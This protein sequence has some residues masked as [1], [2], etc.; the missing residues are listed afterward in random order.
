MTG[1]FEHFDAPPGGSYRLVLAYADAS[2][3][4]SPP[5]DFD[6]GRRQGRP[7]GDAR[8]RVDIRTD[9]VP[10]GINAADRGAGCSEARGHGAGS[11]LMRALHARLAPA[12]QYVLVMVDG[13]RAA[14]RFY[15]RHGLQ[16]ERLVPAHKYYR[17]PAGV[18][19]PAQAEDFRRVLM[20]YRAS[21]AHA[22]PRRCGPRARPSR[23]PSR[24]VATPVT[25]RASDERSFA[26]LLMP[27]TGSETRPVWPVAGSAANGPRATSM[28]A[29]RRC[30]SG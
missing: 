15:L 9:D 23:D 16:R 22:W 3:A 4:G 30:G 12:A 1:R 28:C 29:R 19:F 17:H 6:V 21:A 24:L 2:A 26:P 20:R 18:L 10:D 7:P 27:P 11:A 14:I 5:V 13:N 25:A 8:S